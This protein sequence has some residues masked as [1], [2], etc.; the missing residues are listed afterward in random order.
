MMGKSR[1][2]ALYAIAEFPTAAA[3]AE[4]TFSTKTT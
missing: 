4:K 2:A 1:Q 3:T